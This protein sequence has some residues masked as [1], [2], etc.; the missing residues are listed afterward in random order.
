MF[1]EGDF[2]P[3]FKRIIILSHAAIVKFHVFYGPLFLR[4]SSSVSVPR[5]GGYAVIFQVK[6][7][8]PRRRHG[9]LTGS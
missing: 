3:D 2:V 9:F 5:T 6:L 4:L 8:I 7:R 1:S